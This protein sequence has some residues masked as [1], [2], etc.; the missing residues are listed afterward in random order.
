MDIIENPIENG[1]QAGVVDQPQTGTAQ[2]APRTAEAE[3]G[4]GKSG[5][6]AG[7]GGRQAQS[8]EDNAAARAARIRAERETSERLTREYNRR[9]SDA[10]LRNP[11][12]GA[13]ISDMSELEAYGKQYTDEQLRARA[14][15]EGRSVE[16]LRE[17]EENKAYLR[18][19]REKDAKAEEEQKKQKERRDFLVQDAQ[20]FAERYP[21]VDIVKLES[22]D[23]FK[24]FAKGRLYAEPLG[25]IYEDFV[26]FV[27]EAE[28]GALAKEQ[29]R[30]ARGTGSGG[31]GGATT[32][33]ADEQKA[34]DAWNSAYPSMKM[35]A[36]EFKERG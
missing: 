25:D 15:K 5:G 30:R 2:Q 10:G 11:Y 21:D 22:N 13:R 4:D 7:Q 20:D 31:G 33:T 27:S 34:L 12:T 17:D 28:Q 32:L 24:K 36:K 16:E 1:G 35:T 9:I 19:A 3:A 29:S 8:R 14:K 23:K 18:R 6:G 26:E